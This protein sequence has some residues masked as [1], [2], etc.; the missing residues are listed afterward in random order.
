[1]SSD[2]SWNG[3]VE[4]VLLMVVMTVVEEVV[5][6]VQGQMVR[7]MEVVAVLLTTV[8]AW[9]QKLE[10]QEVLEISVVM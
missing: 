4:S 3:L 9:E 2:R 1:M 7:R 5:V 6:V 10:E 8:E